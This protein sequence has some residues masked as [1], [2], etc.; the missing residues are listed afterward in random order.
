MSSGCAS[1]VGRCSPFGHGLLAVSREHVGGADAARIAI[2][3]G[4]EDA[5][6]LAFREGAGFQVETLQ[7]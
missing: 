3:C 6:L 2:D 7:V 5:A 4:R 1:R